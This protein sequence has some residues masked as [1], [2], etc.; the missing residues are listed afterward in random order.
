MSSFS[1]FDH[2]KYHCGL[3]KLLP[4]ERLETFAVQ[5][6]YH[7]RHV[8]WK[9]LFQADENIRAGYDAYSTPRYAVQIPD[10]WKG[11]VDKYAAEQQTH[12]P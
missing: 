4:P 8:S 5:H 3:N 12:D 9:S 6:Y 2:K 1:V 7:Q 11:I 10:C